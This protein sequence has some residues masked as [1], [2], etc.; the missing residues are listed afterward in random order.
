MSGKEGIS[1]EELERIF[2]E[3]MDEYAGGVTAHYELTESKLIIAR[4]K[5]KELEG[6][7]QY[8]NAGDKHETVSCLELIDRVDVAKVLIEHLIYRKE[9]RWPTF[10]SPYR[11]P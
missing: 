9:T 6:K 1:C 4:E 11:L 7:L 5:L 8:L 3:I 10:Q 2:H